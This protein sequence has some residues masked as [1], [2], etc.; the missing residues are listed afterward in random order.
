MKKILFV[1]L[2]YIPS[3][4]EVKLCDTRGYIFSSLETMPFEYLESGK[5]PQ[6]DEEFVVSIHSGSRHLF[7]CISSYVDKP[8]IVDGHDAVI[9]A[10]WIQR[11]ASN[12]Q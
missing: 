1:K 7:R 8:F 3:T 6:E 5:I 12:I 10:I 9:Y 4:S 2:N 11:A